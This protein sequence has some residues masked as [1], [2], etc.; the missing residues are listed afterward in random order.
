MVNGGPLTLDTFQNYKPQSSFNIDGTVNQETMD[1]LNKM[2]NLET[3]KPPCKGGKSECGVSDDVAKMSDVER[4]GHQ[5]QAIEEA[6]TWK[7]SGT[8]F[9]LSRLNYC[10]LQ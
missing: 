6:E 8:S 10:I 4:I 3:S 1:A 7:V 5:E 2:F 9:T